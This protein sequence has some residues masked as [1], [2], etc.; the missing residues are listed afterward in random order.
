MASL[1][2]AISVVVLACVGEYSQ[3]IL[4][5]TCSAGF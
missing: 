5:L 3:Y 4:G 2:L 1:R